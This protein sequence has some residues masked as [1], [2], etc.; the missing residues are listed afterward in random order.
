TK[1]IVLR[2]ARFALFE[3]SPIHI[4][5]QTSAARLAATV[6]DPPRAT[7][8]TGKS[9]DGDQPPPETMLAAE[10]AGMVT[11]TMAV[12]AVVVKEVE[13]VA[14]TG[15]GGVGGVATAVAANLPHAICWLNAPTKYAARN[16]ASGGPNIRKS[17][18]HCPCTIRCEVNGVA[19]NTSSN[20]L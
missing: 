7:Q 19:S 14:V 12:V 3:F 10:A 4:P 16:N 20:P 2:V 5:N 8:T 9:V 17:A 1:T 13:F 11:V 15:V 18:R 6:I